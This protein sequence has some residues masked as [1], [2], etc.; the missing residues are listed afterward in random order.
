METLLTPKFQDFTLKRFINEQIPDFI[1][2]LKVSKEIAQIQESQAEDSYQ[3]AVSLKGQGYAN[4]D[5]N[6]YKRYKEACQRLIEYCEKLVLGDLIKNN[7]EMALVQFLED[8]RTGKFGEIHRIKPKQQSKKDVFISVMLERDNQP[9]EREELKYL[10]AKK[11]SISISDNSLSSALTNAVNDSGYLVETE[12]NLL[13]LD[14]G[15][16]T[17]KNYIKFKK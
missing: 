12:K 10:T 6:Q 15:H 5:K 11:L 17:V 16:N 13:A 1:L 14:M 3:K 9:I 7:K 4:A 8:V 2:L